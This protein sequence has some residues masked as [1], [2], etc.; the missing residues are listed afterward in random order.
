MAKVAA[1]GEKEPVEKVTQRPSLLKSAAAKAEPV[2][3]PEQKP[4]MA[5]LDSAKT[6]AV[7]CV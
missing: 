3:H 2:A 7:R 5:K 1:T 6:T 4:L